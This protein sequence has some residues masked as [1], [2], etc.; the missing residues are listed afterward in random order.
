MR[1][2]E[3]LIKEDAAE[4][5]DI[6][7]IALFIE[8][9]YRKYQKKIEPYLSYTL[10]EMS[11]DFSLTL[12]AI[13]T[14]LL[15]QLVID[16]LNGNEPLKFFF[17][18]PSQTDKQYGAYGNNRVLINANLLDAN[19]KSIA[20][21]T[22]HEIQHA[23]DDIKSK[24]QA[25]N[26]ASKLGDPTKNLDAYLKL[27]DEVNARFMQAMMKIAQTNTR[28]E[29]NNIMNVTA[30][31]LNDYNLSKNIVGD[32]VYKRLLSRAYKFIIEMNKLAPD[33][34]KPDF[35]SK[36]KSIISNLIKT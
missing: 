22:A 9:F 34:K 28:V 31:S 23:L 4:S 3:I 8:Q 35:F 33:R 27:P 24:G 14:P 13:S 7:S 18:H 20:S 30:Q 19:K 29:Q 12:P 10:P 21:T 2:A 17:N 11:K 1:I 15:K 32:Q 36:V 26:A 25:F 16:G 5:L 6:K